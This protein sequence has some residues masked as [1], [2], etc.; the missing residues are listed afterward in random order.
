MFKRWTLI[1]SLAALTGLL[2]GRASAIDYSDVY[3]VPAESGWGVFVIQSDNFQFVSFF[4]YGPD[5]KP[6]WYTAQLTQDS[7]GNFSGPLF[8]T[9][10]TYFGAQ[11]KTADKSITQ[12]G[13]A[14][15]SPTSATTATL[16]YALT[17]GPSVVKQL[18]RQTLTTI[19]IGGSY[20]GGQSGAYSKCTNANLN[21]PYTDAF[22][23]D[24]TQLA[25]GNATFKFSYASNLSC[26][27][28]GT[29]VQ[30]GTLYSIPTAT[31]QCSDGLNT[32]ASMSE[33]KATSLGIEGRF[34]APSVGS[35]CREDA[36]FSGA[37]TQ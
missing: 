19:T 33:I 34:A 26:T 12:V 5:N 18:Q 13:T 2:A 28:N 8:L 22:N 17:N 25:N 1:L 32:T 30:T 21:G 7:N 37:L 3:Y 14:M 20:V 4:I 24:V 29:L 11:W 10:G 31:Y 23:V 6:T 9:T 16:T 27:F 36:T 35:G 15:F